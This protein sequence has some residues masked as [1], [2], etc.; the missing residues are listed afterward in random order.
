[1]VGCCP[2]VSTQLYGENDRTHLL[3]C[4]HF[5]FAGGADGLVFL[6]NFL[7]EWTTILSPPAY[8]DWEV[9]VDDGA[10]DGWHKVLELLCNPGDPI[11]VEA[12]T[13][14][15]AL[16]SGWPMGVRPVPVPIDADGLI[17][18]GLDKVLAEWDEA[19]RGCKRPRV[20]YTVP[21]ALILR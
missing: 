9:L 6:Q 7:R 2:V 14:P 15:S 3:S 13:Y 20:L 21:G 12:W 19:K 1:M 10:T 5:P 17:P 4:F 11:L 18:E 8:D 16:E